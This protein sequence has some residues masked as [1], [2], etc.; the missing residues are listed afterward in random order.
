MVRLYDVVDT[1]TGL[2]HSVAIVKKR[3]SRFF[4]PADEWVDP[5]PDSTDSDIL[6]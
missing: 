2:Y 1:R 5:N 4:V 6:L 3:N